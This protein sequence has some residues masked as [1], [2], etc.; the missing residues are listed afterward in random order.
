MI[1]MLLVGDKRKKQVSDDNKGS[2]NTKISQQKSVMRQIS[3]YVI[4][5][6]NI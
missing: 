4:E 2:V 3:R 5:A 6:S 1:I